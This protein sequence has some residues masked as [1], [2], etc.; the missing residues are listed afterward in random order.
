[1]VWRFKIVGS[2]DVPRGD[3]ASLISIWKIEGDVKDPILIT[4]YA[5]NGGEG[6]HV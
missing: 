2:I 4:A 5:H 3:Q 6:Q 1:M